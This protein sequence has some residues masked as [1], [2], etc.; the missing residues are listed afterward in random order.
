MR[1]NGAETSNG[2]EKNH[3]D[4]ALSIRQQDPVFSSGIAAAAAAAASCG[5]SNLRSRWSSTLV[6]ARAP[7]TKATDTVADLL[8]IRLRQLRREMRS[9]AKARFSSRLRAAMSPVNAGRSCAAG[10]GAGTLVGTAI[11][12]S[13]GAVFLRNHRT[14]RWRR[15]T[16]REGTARPM[17]TR[18]MPPWAPWRCAG[19]RN[20]GSARFS[21]STLTRGSPRKPHS[22]ASTCCSTS[23]ATLSAGSWRALATRAT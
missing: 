9:P 11:S 21:C 23:A 18:R 16:A 4:H 8:P 7:S 10:P 6:P 22:G 14:R 15:P 19:Y 20:D 1:K 13:G 17:R 3:K 12:G 2:N 5:A